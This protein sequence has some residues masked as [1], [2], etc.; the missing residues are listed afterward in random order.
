MTKSALPSLEQLDARLHEQTV[1]MA[2]LRACLDIQFK[3][4]AQMQAEL[5][6]LPQARRRRQSLLALLIQPSA[7]RDGHTG[8]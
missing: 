5:D 8:Y 3:R 7:S 1:E 4:I 2:S 6:V